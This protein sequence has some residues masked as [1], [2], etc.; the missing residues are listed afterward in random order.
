MAMLSQA[1]VKQRLSSPWTVWLI[2]LIGV[3][4]VLVQTRFGP[5]ASGDSSSYLMGAQNLIAGHG[6][7]RFSGGYELKPITGFPPG[8]S[9]ALAGAGLLLRDLYAAS[10]ALNAVLMGANLILAGWLIHRYTRS[11]LAAALGEI[12][13]LCSATQLNLASWVMSEP[14]YITFSLIFFVCLILYLDG[15]STW[16]IGL[17]GL[18]AAA[19]ILTRFAGLSMTAAGAV[20]M[21]AFGGAALRRRIG[22]IALFSGISLVPFLLWTQR[23]AALAGTRVDRQLAYHAI[24]P[25][26][27]RLFLADISSWFVPH[28]VPL[29]TAARAAVAIFIAVGVLGGFVWVSVR[30]GSGWRTKVSRFDIS[31]PGLAGALPWS[32]VLYLGAYAAV[33]AVNSLLLDASTTATA[34]PRYLAPAYVAAVLLIVCAA[35]DLLAGAAWQR[36]WV[37]TAA[38]YLL[39]LIGYNLW[40][41]SAAVA[42]PFPTLGY[43]ARRTTW[44]QTVGAID[45]YETRGPVVSN[46]PEM[47]YILTG[48]PAYVRPISYDQYQE[49]AREDYQQQLRDIT[50]ILNKGSV[51]VVFEQLEADDT[52]LIDYAGL[53]EIDQTPHAF[54]FALSEG[55]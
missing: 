23:N 29:P 34:P 49:Q 31:H 30:K 12:L 4:V 22:D 47:V 15:G 17:G 53:V 1:R 26:L 16:V 43:T 32:L 21:L 38:V 51:F 28:E 37:V 50:A 10:R 14:L 25:E 11:W 27:V 8:F 24:D 45:G 48:K 6:F 7:Y 13:I 36:R 5:G 35:H 54:F 46:N 33:L 52:S 55:P 42:D 41:A 9:V 2:G 44:E 3:V 39:V 40:D 18:A 20:A 19:G